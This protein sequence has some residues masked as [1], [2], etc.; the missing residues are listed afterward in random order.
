MRDL[1]QLYAIKKKI[2]EELYVLNSQVSKFL[3][4]KRNKEKYLEQINN[5]ITSLSSDLSVSDH[6]IVRY[7]QRVLLYDIEE[8]KK[9]ILPDYAKD[10][11]KK[12]NNCEYPIEDFVAIIKDNNVVTIETKDKCKNKK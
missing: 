4:Q 9:K 1:N 11:V 6:A 8:I 7:F 5:Q 12:L 3:K 2:E 10:V